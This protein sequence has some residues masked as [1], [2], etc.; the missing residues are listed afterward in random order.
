M[1]RDIARFLAP[2]PVTAEPGLESVDPRLIEVTD[3]AT[4]RNFELAADR[5]DEL[6]A[7][8][9]YDIRLLAVYFYQAFREE[10]LPRLA[11]ILAAVE[12]LT[13]ESFEAVG[14]TKRREDQLD[15]R[16]AWLFGE[17]VDALEYHELH[18]TEDSH[19][20]FGVISQSAVDAALSNVEA[21]AEHLAVRE[22]RNAPRAVARLRTWLTSYK[23]ALEAP[24]PEASGGVAPAPATAAPV[25]EADVTVGAKTQIQL[26]VSYRF[27]ELRQ[28]LQA[29]ELLVKRGDYRKAALVADDIQQVAD[30]FDP[31]AYFPE[32]FAS[33]SR[34]V[35]THIAELDSHW[36]QRNEPGWKA[37]Q[38]YFQ[39][40]LDG[41]VEP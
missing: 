11:D 35:A 40:D 34:G 8:G 5:V 15:R 28:K 18:P 41:F 22:L 20:A 25:I 26:I 16:L 32:M 27:L 30:H 31:R 7:D 37:L 19:Q 14:P 1:A 17:I 10:G 2:L 36:Q 24:P 12:R 6:L 3:L 38:Q 21:V 13:G 9:V 39:V 33:F 23:E 29:F 4:R